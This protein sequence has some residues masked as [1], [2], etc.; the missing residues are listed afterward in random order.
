MKIATRDG[1]QIQACKLSKIFNFAQ[2]LL[3][4]FKSTPLV[5]TNHPLVEVRLKFVRF[6]RAQGQEGRKIRS[7]QG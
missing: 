4:G 3:P 5:E 2:E 1:A 7:I 6:S